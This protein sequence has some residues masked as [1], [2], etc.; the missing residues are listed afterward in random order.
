MNNNQRPL[1]R[2]TPSDW[3]HVSKYPFSAVAPKAVINVEKTLKLP[4]FHRGWDQGQQGSCVGF[5]TSMMMSIVNEQQ[6]RTISEKPY[7]HKYDPFWLWNNAKM[8][9]EWPDTNPG[10]DNGTS[11]R[12]ACD[13][14]R[15]KGHVRIKG[16][17]DFP[18]DL[19]EGIS[20]NRWATTVDE[21]RT[22]ISMGIPLSMG[23]NWYSNFDDPKKKGREYWIGEGDL[24]EIRG[25][26]CVCLYGASDKRKAFK[27]KNSWGKLYPEVWIPYDTVKRLISEDGEFAL[28]TDR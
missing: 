5:G 21:I 28:I 16:T 1:G 23:V 12:A 25:G 7:T 3:K 26:H 4:S 10:D 20:T 2:K 27:I 13:I 9:D 11:V 17:K 22:A 6:A 15:T 18:V 8:I 14:L 19:N 24:G